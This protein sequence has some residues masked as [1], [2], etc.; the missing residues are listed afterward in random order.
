MSEFYETT[1]NYCFEKKGV[2]K[3]VNDEDSVIKHINTTSYK[4]LLTQKV[5][6]DGM[7]PKLENCFNALNRNVHQVCIGNISML[8][9]ESNLF[10]TIT[11]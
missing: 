5:I 11:L 6:A 7:L 9:P 8:A 1:L 3:D 10:T 2:L 4:T